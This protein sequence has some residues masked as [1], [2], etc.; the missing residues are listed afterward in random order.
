MSNH[1]PSPRAQARQQERAA[2]ERQMRRR[3]LIGLTVPALICAL[4][5]ISV[6]P[7]SWLGW[8]LIAAELPAAAAGVAV[9]FMLQD[10]KPTA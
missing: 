2:T 3:F 8:V 5:A 7:D 6:G 4:T 9:V 10:R 1:Y